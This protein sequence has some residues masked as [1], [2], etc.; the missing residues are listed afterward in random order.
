MTDCR[1]IGLDLVVAAEVSVP[2]VGTAR[3][4]A[5]AGPIGEAAG[6]S[7]GA[8]RQGV[9]TWTRRVQQEARAGG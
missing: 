8:I 9:R 4:V 1:L 6:A 3:G 5:R 2:A 7:K